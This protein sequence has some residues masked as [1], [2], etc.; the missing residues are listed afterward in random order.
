MATLTALR[1][2]VDIL[3]PLS[4][5]TLVQWV[6]GY[7][8]AHNARRVMQAGSWR[9]KELIP[10][11]GPPRSPDLNPIE[12]LW[13]IMFLSFRRCQVALSSVMPW[14]RSGRK[15]L[16]TPSVVSLGACPDIARQHK[17]TR[18]PY[19]LLSTILS[20]C[21]EISAKRTRLLHHFSL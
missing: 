15:Y 12:H 14:S 1:Y 21:N 8:W 5:P 9:M 19:K 7:S 17:S 4:D 18:G 11:N 20:C 10:L 16:R 13:D 2:H 6:L 3:D